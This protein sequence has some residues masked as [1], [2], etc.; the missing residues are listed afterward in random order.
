[1][2]VG[3]RVKVKGTVETYNL[4]IAHL[5]GRVTEV[6]AGGELAFVVL[7]SGRTVKLCADELEAATKKDEAA[8]VFRGRAA[9]R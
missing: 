9:I 2:K 8:K 7:D 1:M 4:Q 6:R 5:L 3:D